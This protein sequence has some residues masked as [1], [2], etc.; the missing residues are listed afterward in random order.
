MLLYFLHTGWLNVHK[1]REGLMHF[2][3]VACYE[4]QISHIFFISHVSN[5][6]TLRRAHSHKLSHILLYRQLM[7][8]RM[9]AEKSSGHFIR[10]CVFQNG[11]NNL[12][13]PSRPRKRGR[14]K[15]NWN[16]EV[17]KFAVKIAASQTTL[18][19]LWLL[20]MSDWKRKV[21]MLYF[22]SLQLVPHMPMSHRTQ[23]SV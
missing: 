23:D 5:V 1:P 8:I 6:E 15:K 16:S 12:K 20:P 2:K 4:Y 7:L 22:G 18:D 13:E 17:S 9:V 21:S 10:T 14:P 3:F 19:Q 11:L